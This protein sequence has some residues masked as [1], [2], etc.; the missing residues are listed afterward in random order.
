M[1]GQLNY[2]LAYQRKNKIETIVSTSASIYNPNIE[3][4]TLY[5]PTNRLDNE[6]N[7]WF[8]I[9]NFRGSTS[10]TPIAQIGGHDVKVE[11]LFLRLTELN[12]FQSSDYPNIR[13]L[14]TQQGAYYYFQ[15][16]LPSTKVQNKIY[17]M[18]SGIGSRRGNPQIQDINDS[19]E[20]RREYPD[21]IYDTIT[22]RL[23]FKDLSRAKDIYGNLIN[24]YR[25][26][27]EEQVSTFISNRADIS[28]NRDFDIGIRNR[29]EIAR[30]FPKVEALSDESRAR[31]A[32]YINAHIETAGLQRG[33]D[34]RIII[35]S[36]TEFKKY[37]ELLDE[38]FITSEIYEENRVITSFKTNLT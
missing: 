18:I 10:N 35:S 4:Q 37:I 6:E 27:T 20:I 8:Y 33:A 23:I 25:E 1:E 3:Y 15:K 5:S 29:K 7:E 24:L 31:L 26:A 22:D 12:Q 9:E 36:K 21:V 38:R 19:V 17:L 32:E 30:L 14:I 28:L 11:E 16:V 13:W 34:G 2:I